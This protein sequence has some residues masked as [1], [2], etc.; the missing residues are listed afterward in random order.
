MRNPLSRLTG[1]HPAL[2]RYQVQA[3]LRRVTRTSPLLLVG[4]TLGSKF[5][6]RT[7]I[8]GMRPLKLTKGLV[9]LSP[10]T[11]V[12]AAGAADAAPIAM[13]EA[14]EEWQ[15]EHSPASSPAAGMTTRDSS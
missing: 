3:V 13:A 11:A 6:P 4:V 5:F 1:G 8:D 7:P 2:F 12:D 10:L 14:D 15:G 9:A